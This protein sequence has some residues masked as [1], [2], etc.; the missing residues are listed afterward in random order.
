MYLLS[1]LLSKTGRFQ[2]KKPVRALG[3]HV[4]PRGLI[5]ASPWCPAES[6]AVRR[7]AWRRAGRSALVPRGG[8]CAVMMTLSTSGCEVTSVAVA[9][10]T[11]LVTDGTSFLLH[12]EIAFGHV[13]YSGRIPYTFTNRTGSSVYLPNCRGGFDV[14]LQIEEGGE[15]VHAWGPVLLDCLSAPIVI[16]ADEVHETTLGVLGC[17]SGGK[18]GPRLDLPRITSTQ[19]RILWRTG[20]SSYDEDAYPFGEL[21]PLEERVSHSFRLE[22]AR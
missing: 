13:W 20:L 9:E 12:R 18:C 16:E 5:Q 14:G 19:V 11:A 15:W 21:I 2:P 17:T 10:D 3:F 7:V 22:V 4:F 6:G 1:L 8:L